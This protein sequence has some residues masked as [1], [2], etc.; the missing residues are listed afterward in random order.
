M[1]A[2]FLFFQRNP[3][4]CK[5][6]Q[7]IVHYVEI[8]EKPNHQ[9]FVYFFLRSRILLCELFYLFIYLFMPVLGLCCCVESG[10]CP[11]VWCVGFLLQWFLL[12]WSMGSKAHRLQQ[13]QHV[14]SVVAAP[15]LQST[16]SIVVMHG[17]SCSEVYEI[18]L[19]QGSNPCLLHWQVD[20][21]PLRHQESPCLLFLYHYK[22]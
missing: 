22:M 19:T 21:L 10:G 1:Y 9:Q 13:L 2:A 3:L 11:L 6:N 4:A 20:S 12:L 7:N 8:V 18:F 17:L 15:R 14:G 5:Q 16:G